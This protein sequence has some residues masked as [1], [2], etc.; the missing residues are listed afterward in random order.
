MVVR[1]LLAI[2]MAAPCL[3]AALPAAA[4]EAPPP[5]PTKT[6][7]KTYPVGTRGSDV[8]AMMKADMVYAAEAQFEEKEFFEYHLYTL[9]QPATLKDRQTKQLSLFP[10]AEVPVQKLYI[11]DPGQDEKNNQDCEYDDDRMG[12]FLFFCHE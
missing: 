4:G 3:L 7:G 12:Y 9:Q 1:A 11:Y 2:A 6:E 8:R 5:A 10:A